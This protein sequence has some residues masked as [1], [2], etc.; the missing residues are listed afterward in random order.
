MAYDPAS[1]TALKWESNKNGGHIDQWLLGGMEGDLRHTQMIP[2]HRRLGKEVCEFEI[3][4]SH[5]VILM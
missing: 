1:T 4:Q 3:S 5:T 2:P